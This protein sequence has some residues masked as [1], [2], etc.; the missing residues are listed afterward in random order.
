MNTPNKATSLQ[1]I[2]ISTPK[3]QKTLGRLFRLVVGIALVSQDL[4]RQQLPIWEAEVARRVA[5]PPKRLAP[6]PSSTDV[7]ATSPSTPWVPPKWEH[8]LVGLVFESPNYIKS[9]VAAIWRTEQKIWQKTAPLRYPLDLLGIS[10]MTQRTMDRI[11]SRLQSDVERL[12]RIG[13]TEVGP[14]KALASVAI[15]DIYQK[16]LDLLAQSPEIRGLIAQ[17]SAGVTTEV[18]REVRERTVSADTLADSLTRRIL[19]KTPK[20]E[21]DQFLPKQPEESR[22]P[23]W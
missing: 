15:A 13:E 17:Q 3:E 5:E 7:Q 21:P 19:R 20:A 4:V 8:R 11:T 14:S 6:T 22:D 1:V 18:I 9:G 10:G 12:E 2:D 23:N 16:V